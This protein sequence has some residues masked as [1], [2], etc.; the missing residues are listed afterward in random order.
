MKAAALAFGAASIL[1]RVNCGTFGQDNSRGQR[2]RVPR[3]NAPPCRQGA[4]SVTYKLAASI[5]FPP[6]GEA[7]KAL[8]TPS[9]P[10]HASAAET[11]LPREGPG[12]KCSCLS[13][14]LL[15][16]FIFFFFFTADSK[17]FSDKNFQIKMSQPNENKTVLGSS[18]RW[19]QR[20]SLCCLFLS[21]S[22]SFFF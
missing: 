10:L 4:L 2:S 21:F 6:G 16:V 11:S 19:Q 20:A 5:S 14:L 12:A 9:T 8:R 7:A 3:W 15:D 18:A 17:Q 22:F 13:L 1:S